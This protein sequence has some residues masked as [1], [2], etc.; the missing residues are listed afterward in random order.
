MIEIILHLFCIISGQSHKL[1]DS[2]F[3]CQ[4]KQDDGWET[5]P[6]KK[7]RKKD[8]CDSATQTSELEEV[9]IRKLVKE[10]QH[11][12]KELK[13]QYKISSIVLKTKNKA[14]YFTGL[15][16]IERKIIWELLGTEDE[17]TN[18]TIFRSKQRKKTQNLP[19]KTG[20]LKISI[21]D[22][23]LLC[24]VK[25]RRGYS[26]LDISFRFKLVADTISA[27]V[28][29]W[30]SLMYTTFKN[31]QEDMF[32]KSDQISKPVPPHF[33]NTLLR[34]VRYVIDCSEIFVE[35]SKDQRQQGNLYSHTNPTRLENYS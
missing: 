24:L 26:Y 32:V 8:F 16:E 11:L 28:K 30:L 19:K 5:P 34:D 17:L 21:E 14:R 33:R 13:G 4:P 3:S 9:T 35:S 20:D 6:P 29:T 1:E 25:I 12:R 27:V 18:L 10:N 2:P 7:R 22:Q 15:S 31:F 23:L